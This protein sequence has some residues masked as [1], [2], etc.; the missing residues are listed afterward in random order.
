MS[1]N[2]LQIY[3]Q[4]IYF[5][6][7][8]LAVM[9]GYVAS[10]ARANVDG[11]VQMYLSPASFR[12]RRIDAPGRPD[13]A[14]AYDGDGLL[15]ASFPSDNLS[16]VSLTTFFVRDLQNAR[17]AGALLADLLKDHGAGKE[18]L[19]ALEPLVALLPK[20]AA[21]GSMVIRLLPKVASLISELLKGRKDAIKIYADGTRSFQD[22]DD[23]QDSSMIWG[24]SR[25]DKGYFRSSWDFCRTSNPY[26][27]VRN[28]VLPDALKAKLGIK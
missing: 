15:V 22:P 14:H 28:L 27:A 23:F 18:L 10:F 24:V 1:H 9:R 13:L 5:D 11:E 17:D 20:S 7:P 21:A 2:T 4:D 12:I 8:T 25:S 3:L 16:S 19:D 26:A 6:R